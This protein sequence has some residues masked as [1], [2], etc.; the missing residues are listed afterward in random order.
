MPERPGP[1]SAKVRLD[2][3]LMDRRLST[4]RQRARALIMA[5]KVLVADRVCDKPG[6]RFPPE[7]AISLRGEDIPYVSR[8]GVKLAAILDALALDIQ[9]WTCL[10]VGAST[11]G[12]TDCLLQHGACRVYAVDVGYGQLAWKLRRDPRV[13]PIE[14]TNIRYLAVDALPAAVDL[15]TIDT[16]F[17]SLRIVVPATLRFLRPGGWMI[18]LIKPQFE[19]GRG[20]VGKGGVVRDPDRHQA[21][22]DELRAFF[23]GL[24]LKVHT[25]LP[26]P[27]LGP[28]G[29]REFLAA[30]TLDAYFLLE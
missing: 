2:Q 29:N 4:S 1:S 30:L 23:A 18:A 10:D 8:G 19:V 17:I 12:F 3:L 28:K 6:S 15:A 5:G 24:G 7:S 11:G 25:V 21:V 13:I 22:I 14:R 9:D 20:Q 16:S 26:S 27:I